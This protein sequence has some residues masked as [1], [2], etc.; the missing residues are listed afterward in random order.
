LPYRRRPHPAS[1][2]P[3]TLHPPLSPPTPAS[4]DWASLPWDLSMPY[5]EASKVLG[6]WAG[7]STAGLA[8]GAVL[9]LDQAQMTEL[10]AET[11]LRGNKQLESALF[12][13]ADSV[14]KAFFGDDVYCELPGSVA[15]RC[16]ALGREAAHPQ[17]LCFGTKGRRP[18]AACSV[19]CAAALR[20]QG[21]GRTHAIQALLA[22]NL[23]RGGGFIRAPCP[24]PQT[25]SLTPQTHPLPQTAASSSFPTSAPMTVATAASAS[26]RRTWCGT[27]CLR[28]R[29]CR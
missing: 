10:L 21:C 28:R 20:Q 23:P 11:T 22:P 7:P 26:T 8:P 29:W 25:M 14:T 6:A 24:R 16:P 15:R 3:H 2:P 1:P 27:P 12:A 5:E 4:Q 9:P 13:H 17:P 18:S 19:G